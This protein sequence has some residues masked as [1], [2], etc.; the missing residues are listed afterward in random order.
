[1][2]FL[3]PNIFVS[4]KIQ[5]YIKHV[6]EVLM[7]SLHKQCT[8]QTL[9]V[10]VMEET[11]SI[12]GGITRGTVAEVQWIDPGTEQMSNIHKVKSLLSPNKNCPVCL[13]FIFYHVKTEIDMKIRENINNYRNMIFMCIIY[14]NFMY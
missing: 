8:V 9:E 6:H 14:N 12:S 3:L 7:S 1:M 10:D 13:L 11:L 2:N 5:I 4:G